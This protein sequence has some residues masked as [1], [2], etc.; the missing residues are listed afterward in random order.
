MMN[1]ETDRNHS[2]E[3]HALPTVLVSIRSLSKHVSSHRVWAF[4]VVNDACDLV[5]FDRRNQLDVCIYLC[6]VIDASGAGRR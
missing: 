2:D 6:I 4:D 5:L 1:L 3:P